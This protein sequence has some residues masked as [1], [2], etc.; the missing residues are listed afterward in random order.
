VDR[1]LNLLQGNIQQER[2]DIYFQAIQHLICKSSA[3]VKDTG[4][5]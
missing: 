2:T 1:C 5:Y 4:F 3:D